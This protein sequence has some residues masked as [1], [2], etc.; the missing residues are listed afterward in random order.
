MKNTHEEI[1]KAIKALPKE[2]RLGLIVAQEQLSIEEEALERAVLAQQ[3]VEEQHYMERGRAFEDLIMGNTGSFR[4]LDEMLQGMVKLTD[5]LMAFRKEVGEHYEL[6]K[7]AIDRREEGANKEVVEVIIKA[8]KAKATA[9]AKRKTQAKMAER[10]A[11]GSKSWHSARQKVFKAIVPTLV[12]T[13][14]M[15]DHYP[16]QEVGA[17]KPTKDMFTKCNHPA[18]KNGK[19]HGDYNRKCYRCDGKGHMVLKDYKRLAVKLTK[20][21][22]KDEITF[23]SKE[24]NLDNDWEITLPLTA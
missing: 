2:A 10:I 21:G 5:E 8:K 23:R 9:T 22:T 12:D 6:Q 20:I 18:C 3:E 17:I 4:P 24:R 1:M 7:N 19:Y 15:K 11:P 14:Y 13:Q 16:M